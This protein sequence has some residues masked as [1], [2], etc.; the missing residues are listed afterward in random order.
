VAYGVEQ[1]RAGTDRHATTP[2]ELTHA[3]QDLHLEAPVGVAIRDRDGRFVFVNETMARM[4]GRSAD[5]VTRT[6]FGAATHPDDRMHL[7][8]RW[9]ALQ[10]GDVDTYDCETRFLHE[11][12]S[13][14]WARVHVR[15][16]RDARGHLVLAVLHAQ[17]ISEQKAFELALAGSEARTDALLRHAREV[18]MIVDPAGGIRYASPAVE[19]VLGFDASVFDETHPF[20][21]LHPDDRA[22]WLDGWRHVSGR[23]A[24]RFSLTTRI[25]H[26]DGSY[27]WCEATLRDL[28]SEPGVDGYLAHFSDVSEKRRT[29]DSLAARALHDGLTGLANRALLVDRLRHALDRAERSGSVVALLFCDLDRFKPIN[30]SFGHATGDAV[31]REVAARLQ[32]VV[33]PA[34]TVARLG[35]DEFVVCCEDV[36]SGTEAVL[37]AERIL[38]ALRA[39]FAIDGRQISI[40]TSVGIAVA[41]RGAED[42]DG[43]LRS[44]DA[45]MYTAKANGR[46]R[47][48]VFDDGIRARLRHRIEI[49]DGV[50]HA[51]DADELRLLYQPIF[52]LSTPDGSPRVVGVEA[53]VRWLHPDRGLLR[54]AE[55]LPIAAQSGA[56]GRVTEWVIEHTCR[57]VACWRRKGLEVPTVWVNLAADQLAQPTIVSTIAGALARYD[58]P[59]RTLGFDVAEPMLHTLGAT[60]GGGDALEALAG[61]GCSLALDDYGTGATALR[62][63]RRFGLTVLKL[64]P[65]LWGDPSDDSLLEQA[66]GFGR[67]LGLTVVAEAIESEV[68]LAV[69]EDAGCDCVTGDHLGPPASADD[70]AE[71]FGR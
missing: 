31:L 30:D 53:L 3:L 20:D 70:V 28:T 33:R 60:P 71:L 9:E 1:Q 2:P 40:S 4:L 65:S 25:L 67:L 56:A 45:A 26:A 12:G 18:V 52:A 62:S 5:A 49:E 47:Y 29:E 66:V 46:D 36:V 59:A 10:R 32:A 24:D 23:A 15:A 64:D 19:E 38:S 68:Q 17:D 48:E 6:A 44:A 7:R 21:L 8:A 39:P 58:L 57:Q 37:L 11:D 13:A 54:P 43:M 27:R 35:G 50:R 63:V 16:H 51:L 22:T 61:L 42:P 34:D 41:G 55:F 14:V 69:V